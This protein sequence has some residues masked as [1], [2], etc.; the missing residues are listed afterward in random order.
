MRIFNPLAKANELVQAVLAGDQTAIR[1]AIGSPCVEI[2]QGHL[3][4]H[5]AGKNGQGQVE[6]P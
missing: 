4:P 5:I 3:R 2:R 1:N 6:G